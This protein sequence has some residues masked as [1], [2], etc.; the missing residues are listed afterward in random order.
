MKD[1]KW[2]LKFLV[3]FFFIIFKIQE[4]PK[5]FVRK[6]GEA[7]QG[8][9]IYLK[10]ANGGK[11]KVGL[12]KSDGKVWFE[13]GWEEFTKFYSFDIGYFLTFRYEGNF[14]FYVVIFD[15]SATEIEY[16]ITFKEYDNKIIS[17][18][19]NKGFQVLVKKEKEEFEENICVKT[20]ENKNNIAQTL[21]SPTNKR[22]KIRSDQ[23]GGRKVICKS[24]EFQKLELEKKEGMYS[25]ELNL[26]TCIQF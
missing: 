12:N 17:D 13:K 8:D 5:K 24:H 3:F 21:L 23:A 6:H 10:V 16:S 15:H 18:E 11:W 9:E 4:V 25:S 1:K 20:M 14:C 19:K 7:V 2:G 22:M 26:G